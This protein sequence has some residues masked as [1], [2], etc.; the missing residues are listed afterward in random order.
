MIR[1]T[2]KALLAIDTRRGD[3]QNQV[4]ASWDA[5]GKVRVDY[6]AGISEAFDKFVADGG[7]NSFEKWRKE[8]AV[9]GALKLQEA[10]G[11]QNEIRATIN[12]HEEELRAL[13]DEYWTKWHACLSEI[14]GDL[15]PDNRPINPAP[16]GIRPS[17]SH[18][19]TATRSGPSRAV[20]SSGPTGI[21]KK[22]A[23][24]AATTTS[25]RPPASPPTHLQS[26]LKSRPRRSARTSVASS[27][28]AGTQRNQ[29]AEPPSGR[30]DDE[31]HLI[32]DASQEVT[33]LPPYP[34]IIRPK[35]GEVYQAYYPH[36]KDKG[37]Y[38][39]TPLPW[40]GN[41]WVKELN[42]EYAMDRMDLVNDFP[43][44]YEPLKTR[45]AT[46]KVDAE[47]NP[48]FVETVTAITR[49][50]PGFEDRG[51]KV[52]DRRFLFLYFDDRPNRPGKLTFP[53]TGSGKRKGRSKTTTMKFAKADSKNWSAPIDWVDVECLRPAGVDAPGIRGRATMQKFLT[54]KK[55]LAKAG[56]E[57]EG[58][59]TGFSADSTRTSTDD[60]FASNPRAQ[61]DLNAHEDEIV[62]PEVG[63]SEC[64]PTTVPMGRPP[65]RQPGPPR[66]LAHQRYTPVPERA[67]RQVVIDEN[68]DDDSDDQTD[69]HS[70]T[71]SESQHHTR[72]HNRGKPR[73]RGGHQDHSN[74][75]SFK[76]DIDENYDR[77]IATMP[78][79]A[80]T[81][82]ANK[83][84]EGLGMDYDLELVQARGGF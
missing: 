45:K 1:E 60:T 82:D 2:R 35:P 57:A 81:D 20:N 10:T 15:A 25:S 34:P 36:D 3:V 80:A 74:L 78:T 77:V 53:K 71:R 65:P 42:L 58:H 19:R 4:K 56:D 23:T 79:D 22:R 39:G 62:D 49:W 8:Y 21:R 40:N 11:K 83:F 63:T 28:A 72:Q 48:E 76:M 46:E 13:D 51:P 55:N 12:A 14:N 17:Q 26:N 75:Y 33:V 24:T 9:K 32:Q 6:W 84:D 52:K 41:D 7:E 66:R 5:T 69:A 54:M 37:W 68:Y 61:A 29:V 73:L 18:R 30:N 70:S 50:A 31:E 59:V 43:E 27:P 47:G 64:S 38:F 67:A 44:C 16:P